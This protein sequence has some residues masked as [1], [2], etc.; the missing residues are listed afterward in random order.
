MNWWSHIACLQV[1]SDVTTKEDTVRETGDIN[2]DTAEEA[3]EVPE[4]HLSDLEEEP[5]L[6]QLSKEEVGRVVAARWTGEDITV[7]APKELTHHFS[8]DN[9]EDKENDNE[10]EDDHDHGHEDNHD[11]VNGDGDDVDDSYRDYRH[12]EPVS[13]RFYN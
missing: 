8:E 9:D 10:L 2:D 13:C 5:D 6:E 7:H 4:V 1:K 3:E 11:D 12:P